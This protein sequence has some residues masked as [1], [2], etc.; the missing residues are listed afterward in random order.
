M[1]LF[2]CLHNPKR[3]GGS[4]IKNNHITFKSYHLI[5]KSATYAYQTKSVPN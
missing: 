4:K 5:C 3:N 2:L 1:E